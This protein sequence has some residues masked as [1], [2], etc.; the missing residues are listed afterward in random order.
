MTALRAAISGEK[1]VTKRFE[2][3]RI[4][5]SFNPQT[6]EFETA[7]PVLKKQL[8]WIYDI[9]DYLG[10]SSLAA[11]KGYMENNPEADENH[12]FAALQ[13]LAAIKSAPIGII[14]LNN[15][16]DIEP[17]RDILVDDIV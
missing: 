11:L 5:I 13:K 17:W 6:E 16:L 15:D 2:T 14:S 4:I 10:D 3:K 9:R 12:V 8:E 7:T 1:I